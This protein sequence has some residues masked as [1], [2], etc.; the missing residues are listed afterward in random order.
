[1]CDLVFKRVVVKI[2]QSSKGELWNQE[3]SVLPRLWK[4]NTLLFFKPET[5]VVAYLLLCYLFYTDI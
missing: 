1:M 2:C 5:E 4:Q 3:G